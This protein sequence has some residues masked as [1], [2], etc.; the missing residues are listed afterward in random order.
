[1]P[2]TIASVRLVP[3]APSHPG[4]AFVCHLHYRDNP[5]PL[6]PL[7]TSRA[8][9][10]PAT[11]V[12]VVHMEIW[13]TVSPSCRFMCLVASGGRRCCGL[14]LD[15]SSAYR[16]VIFSNTA[17]IGEPVTGGVERD[18]EYVS[19]LPT[20]YRSARIVELGCPPPQVRGICCDNGV[21]DSRARSPA[22][23]LP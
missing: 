21:A 20:S 6:P 14:F 3:D 10:G 11:P 19:D 12:R 1:M 22:D 4:W 15:G 17:S 2:R 5:G 9:N 23:E 13:P 8:P 7:P 16:M 18:I